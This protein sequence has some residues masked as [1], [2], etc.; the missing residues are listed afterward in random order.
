MTAAPN[1][2]TT[3]GESNGR[4]TPAVLGAKLDM[5][6][7]KVDEIYGT[8]KADHDKLTT[9]CTKFEDIDTL[10]KAAISQAVGLIIAALIAIYALV[11]G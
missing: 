4:V 10:K 3:S 9:V 6:T 11:G 8:L 7:S 5:L 2:G 1:E